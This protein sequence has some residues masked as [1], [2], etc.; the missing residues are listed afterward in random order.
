M[1]NSRQFCLICR[2]KEATPSELCVPASKLSHVWLPGY[3]AGASF[4]RLNASF[5]LVSGRLGPRRRLHVV[6][7]VDG[8]DHPICIYS[9]K[10]DHHRKRY[11]TSQGPLE[12]EALSFV[13][14]VCYFSVYF[15]TGV[16]TVYTDHDPLVFLQRMANHN[17]KLLR[18]SL[19]LQ[20]Y[21]FNIVHRAGKDNLTADLLSR[22]AAATVSIV[23]PV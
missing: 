18:W 22:S 8:L 10:L 16:I 3:A 7:D 20:Q 23:I 9:K 21:N 19:E 15:W 11:S 2:R 1:P 13:L 17:Q 12:K 6:P 4:A 5:L 14:A